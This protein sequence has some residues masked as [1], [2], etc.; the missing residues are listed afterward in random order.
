M[1]CKNDV[2]QLLKFKKIDFWTEVFCGKAHNV[3]TYIIEKKTLA[4]TYFLKNHWESEKF[5]GL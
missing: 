3:I 2:A 1:L 5:F 4:N